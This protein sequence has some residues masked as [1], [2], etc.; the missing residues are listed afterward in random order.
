M[1]SKEFGIIIDR[2]IDQIRDLKQDLQTDIQ[3]VTERI[4]GLEKK[5]REDIKELFKISN[6]NTTSFAL[7]DQKIK[8]HHDQHELLWKR[9]KMQVSILA[10]IITLTGVLI[11]LIIRL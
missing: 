1:D 6:S 8:D 7:L 2:I 10:V 5:I 9:Q 4:D 11:S 3:N